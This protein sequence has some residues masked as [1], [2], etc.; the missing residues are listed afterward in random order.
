MDHTKQ[1]IDE[2]VEKQTT[3]KETAGLVSHLLHLVGIAY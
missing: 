1:N 2:R 3:V